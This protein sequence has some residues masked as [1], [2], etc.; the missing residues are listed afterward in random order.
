MGLAVELRDGSWLNT[1][2]AKPAMNAFWTTQSA[3]TLGVTALLLCLIAAYI[4]RGITRPMRQMARTSRRPVADADARV[5]QHHGCLQPA[6]G[7]SQQP[8][9]LR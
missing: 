8:G 1:A 3:A 5:D 6:G 9:F 4:A 2:F 7:S